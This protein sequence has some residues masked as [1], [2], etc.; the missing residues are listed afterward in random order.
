MEALISLEEGGEGFEGFGVVEGNGVL[1]DVAESDDFKE[2]L[3]SFR[4]VLLVVLRELIVVFED[5]EDFGVLVGF[6]V[7]VDFAV[8]WRMG[9]LVMF[10]GAGGGEGTWVNVELD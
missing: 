8:C 6:D 7:V 2:L 1:T 4:R 3:I 9:E 10:R 5:V